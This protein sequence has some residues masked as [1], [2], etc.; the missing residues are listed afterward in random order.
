MRLW[1]F[2]DS[3][4]TG[5][6]LLM[7][8]FMSISSFQQ[9]LRSPCSLPP[10][11]LQFMALSYQCTW[12]WF[13]GAFCFSC[14]VKLIYFR[15]SWRVLWLHHFDTSTSFISFPTPFLIHEILVFLLLSS[16]YW[17]PLL[18]IICTYIWDWLQELDSLSG[19]G[20]WKTL[21]FYKLAALIVAHLCMGAYEIFHIH[22]NMPSG[23][24]NVKKFLLRK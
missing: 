9:G 12:F 13:V 7:L 16:T 4:Q 3:C 2:L 23:I 14:L 8:I 11:H 5:S 15:M 6:G 17:V 1:C 21:M 24:F 19:E 10:L 20:P 18:L 22:F